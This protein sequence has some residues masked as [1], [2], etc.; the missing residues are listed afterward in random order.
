MRY[1][2]AL[3]LLHKNGM[4]PSLLYSLPKDFDKFLNGRKEDLKK[5]IIDLLEDIFTVKDLKVLD[6]EKIDNALKKIEL[7]PEFDEVVL[8]IIYRSRIVSFLLKV[9]GKEKES[10][11]YLN[12][13]EALKQ[14]PSKEKLSKTDLFK[15]LIG[16]YKKIN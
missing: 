16:P 9:S 7:N 4:G 2:G 10:N 13:S 6:E 15:H 14:M 5:I 12:L 1:V 11:G 8:K 3:N